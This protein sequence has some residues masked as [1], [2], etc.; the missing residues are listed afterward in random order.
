MCDKGH[1]FWQDPSD[2]Y[3]TEG[4]NHCRGLSKEAGELRFRKYIEDKSGIVTGQYINNCTKVAV[5]CDKGHNFEIQPSNTCSGQWCSK[6]ANTCPKQAQERFIRNASLMNGTVLGQ[7]K[8]WEPKYLL[9][10]I[11]IMY[12]I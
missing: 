1:A 2:L 11:S 10:A 5:I 7:Y 4:C 6:C 3:R 8:N 12:L 9:N